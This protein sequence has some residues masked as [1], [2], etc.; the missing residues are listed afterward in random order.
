MNLTAKMNQELNEP[1][2]EV[3]TKRPIAESRTVTA[4]EMCAEFLHELTHPRTRWGRWRLNRRHDTL[5]FHEADRGMLYEIDLARREE[6]L[7]GVPR[8]DLPG[9]SKNLDDRQGPR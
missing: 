7:R 1:A 6:K 4:R 8:L 2:T 3:S 9:Q 5:E